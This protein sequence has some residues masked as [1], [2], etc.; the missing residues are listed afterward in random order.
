MAEITGK[1]IGEFQRGVLKILLD[2]PEALPVKEILHRMEQLVPPTSFEQMDYPKNPGMRRYEK[3][4]R[5][6]TIAP[7]K[8]GWLIKAKGKWYLTEEGKNAYSKYP[9]PED[10][11]RE[12]NRLF[13]QWREKQ[14]KERERSAKTSCGP[15]PRH[16]LSRILDSSIGEARRGKR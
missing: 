8:A 6:A 16:G 7:V 12:A 2:Q 15:A 11:S 3:T 14:P 9:N 1:R 5:F 4:I 10:C 13:Y